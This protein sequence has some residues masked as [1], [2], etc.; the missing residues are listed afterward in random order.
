LLWRADKVREAVR[1]TCPDV[2]EIHSPY[3]AAA[4]CLSIPRSQFGIRTFFW[5]SDFID[6]HAPRLL[7]PLWAWVRTITSRCDRTIVASEYQCAK[8]VRHGA[9]RVE[10]IPMGVEREF[11]HPNVPKTRREELARGADVLLVAV[12]R[13]AFEKRWDVVL[14]AVSLLRAGGMRVRLALI[15]DG[16]ERAKLAARADDSIA[17]FP[18]ETDRKSLAAALASADVLVHGCP[19]ETFGVAIAEAVAC[20]V[21]IVVPDEGAAAEHV[22][23]AAGRTYRTGDA[24]DCARA[25]RELLAADPRERNRAATDAAARVW[26]IEQHF[27]RTIEL[28]ET[29]LAERRA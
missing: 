11:F 25:V 1:R 4:A 28:Y 24:N 18:F 9:V 12:G 22:R 10:R 19:F 3:I 6:T 7:R 8:L 20:G 21:P 23:G 27:D 2:L 15:G 5:H 16:P 14:D 13:F 29:A 17:L 26:S